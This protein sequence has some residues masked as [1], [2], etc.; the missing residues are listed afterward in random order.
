MLGVP[1]QQSGL[2][3]LADDSRTTHSGCKLAWSGRGKSQ[4]LCTL[5]VFVILIKFSK[6]YTRG[7]KKKDSTFFLC[8]IYNLGKYSIKMCKHRQTD[9]SPGLPIILK[10]T[11]LLP[12]HEKYH[13]PDL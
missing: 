2:G 6:P 4:Y 3:G 11:T 9:V 1:V 7:Q 10:F 13:S 8:F 5:N 12:E